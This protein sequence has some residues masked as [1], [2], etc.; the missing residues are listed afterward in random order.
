[1]QPPADAF[2]AAVSIPLLTPIKRYCTEAN[3]RQVARL[4]PAGR[5]LTYRGLGPKE[6][7]GHRRAVSK[8][9]MSVAVLEGAEKDDVAGVGSDFGTAKSR[10]RA[11][12]QGLRNI[13]LSMYAT[14]HETTRSTTTTKRTS[15]IPRLIQPQ[16]LSLCHPGFQISLRIGASACDFLATIAPSPRYQTNPPL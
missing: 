9:R 8:P 5:R 11:N 14:I 12:F 10:P 6:K 4:G 7:S 2:R 1:M 15:D 3:H 16:Q 13:F